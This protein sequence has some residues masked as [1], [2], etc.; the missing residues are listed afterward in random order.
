MSR[1]KPHHRLPIAVAATGLVAL[2]VVVGTAGDAPS[3]RTKAPPLTQVEPGPPT[4]LRVL[5]GSELADM[6]PILVEAAKAT[7]VTVKMDFI[8]S[9]DGAQAV[10]ERKADGKYDAVWFS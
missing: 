8:G 6:Q 1:R 9:L 5:A 4:T 7:G 2:M 10:A 3:D